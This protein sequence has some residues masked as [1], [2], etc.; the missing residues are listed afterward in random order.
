MAGGEVTSAE[1][2]TSR[3]VNKL[4]LHLL[5]WVAVGLV[6]AADAQTSS[7]NSVVRFRLSYGSTFFGD[8]DVEMFDKDKPLTVSNFL[9]NVQ[10]GT[11]ENTIVHDLRPGFLMQGGSVAVP[12][13]YSTGPFELITRV[14]TGAPIPNEVGAGTRRPN[15]FGTLAMAKSPGTTNSS[16]AAWFFNMGNNADGYGVTNLDAIDGGYTVFGRVKAGGNVLTYMNTFTP[17][18]GLQNMTNDFHIDFCPPLYLFP[19]NVNLGF[20]SIPVGYFG[21]DCIRFN[22]TFNVQLL[23]TKEQLRSF[24]KSDLREMGFLASPMPSYRGTL[25]PQEIADM[26]SY[27][28][29]LRG[30]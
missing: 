21:T 28:S 20:D 25:S 17:G 13:P 12:N 27:L 11:Y 10:S 7:T 22:D 1:V 4:K 29:S 24:A 2:V 9:A 26:V 30:Q 14:S 19:D 18:N 15:A 3:N 6:S 23:D 8:V 16:T 5:A